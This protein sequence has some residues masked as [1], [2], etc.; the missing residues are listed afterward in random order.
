MSIIAGQSVINQ[1]HNH[2]NI[3]PLE[4]PNPA[5]YKGPYKLNNPD[6]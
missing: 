3:D 6:I 4:R 5:D 2:N 1:N